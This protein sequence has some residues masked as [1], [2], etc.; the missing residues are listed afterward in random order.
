ME[1]NAG[2]LPGVAARAKARPSESAVSA[3]STSRS[4]RTSMWSDTNPTGITTTAFVPDF[5]SSPR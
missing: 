4:C 2:W 3:A 1:T 5:D